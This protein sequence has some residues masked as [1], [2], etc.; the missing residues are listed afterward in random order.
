MMCGHLWGKG[1]REI[2]N[3]SQ[4]NRYIGGTL[5]IFV[6]G[7]EKHAGHYGI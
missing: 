7:I 2:F 4:K 3:E 5:S 1:G 6:W